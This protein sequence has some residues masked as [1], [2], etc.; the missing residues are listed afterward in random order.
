MSPE[1]RFAKIKYEWIG[2]G[3]GDL[4]AIN[5]AMAELLLRIDGV[6]VI[7]VR[8]T[9]NGRAEYFSD[10][11]HLTPAGSEALAS[12]IATGMNL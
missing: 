2:I 1:D 8:P 5:Q 7:D 6:Q 10:H 3:H 11:V 9:M 12:S 4:L